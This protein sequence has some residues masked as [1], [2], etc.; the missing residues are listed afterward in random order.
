MD[1]KKIALTEPPLPCSS[2][3]SFVSEPRPPQWKND[4]DPDHHTRAVFSPFVRHGSAS[5]T[6]GDAFILRLRLFHSTLPFDKH[7]D[8]RP[9]VKTGSTRRIIYKKLRVHEL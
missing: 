7:Q 3:A 8:V 6:F 1:E 5:N 2:P 9:V 4:L